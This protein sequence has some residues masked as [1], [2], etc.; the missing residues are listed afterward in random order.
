MPAVMPAIL[1]PAAFPLLKK[2]THDLPLSIH[3]PKIFSSYNYL[4]VIYYQQMIYTVCFPV[5]E[6][7]S[8]S[9]PVRLDIQYSQSSSNNGNVATLFELYRFTKSSSKSRLFV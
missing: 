5:L 3:H 8:E 9:S 1:S 2:L 4:L 6:L 7:S